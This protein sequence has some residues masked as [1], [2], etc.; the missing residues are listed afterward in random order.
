MPENVNDINL[1]RVRFLESERLFLTPVNTDDIE[2]NFLWEQD[3]EMQFL[4]GWTYRPEAFE[5]YREE[6]E[7]IFKSKKAM[8]LSIIL[9]ETGGHIGQIVL[10]DIDDYGRTAEWGLKLD[11]RF[12]R[13][14]YA[15]EAARLLVRY[16]FEELGFVRLQ[17]GT[18]S[19]NEA[20]VNLLDKLGFVKEGVR[21]KGRF[22]NGEYLD[23][24]MYG[25]LKED[26]EN[27]FLKKTES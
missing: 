18:H 1:K 5:K 6:F 14:G 12:R 19:R 21:R 9:K 7:G 4:D 15:A 8:F 22:V 24:L 23:S 20:S 25:M 13:Q 17:S 26:Y 2:Q 11:Q 16:V 10:F 27:N 3:R